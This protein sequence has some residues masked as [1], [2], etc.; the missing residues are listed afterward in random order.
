MRREF[1]IDGNDFND[2]EGFYSE[3]D[4]LLTKDLTWD[5]GHN[6]DAFNDI[7][8]GGFGVHEYGEPI[9]IVWKNFALSRKAFGYEATVEHYEKMLSHCH[10][11]NEKSVKAL[12]SDAKNRTGE[13]LLDKIVH[14]ILDTDDSGHDC[15]LEV[16]E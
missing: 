8:R 10:P 3:I 11:S 4:R 1:L 2:I 15:I 13:T 12:L 9:K 6:L 5:T 7:L 14:I 16:I